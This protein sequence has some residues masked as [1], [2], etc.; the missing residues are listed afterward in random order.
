MDLATKA[1]PV[2]ALRMAALRE[3]VL[4]AA[5]MLTTTNARAPTPEV[6]AH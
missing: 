5:Y 4:R 2:K 3:F 1:L 6:M